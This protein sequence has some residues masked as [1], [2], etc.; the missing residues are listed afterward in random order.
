MP[1]IDIVLVEPLYEGNI[2][3]CARVMK[4]FGFT[5]LVLVNPPEIGGEAVARASHARDVL[6]GAERLTFDEV[7]GRSS[8]LVATTGEV[9]S[10]ICTSIR[11]P[12]FS[13]AELREMLADVDGRIAILFGREN[14]GLSNSPASPPGRTG[15]RAAWSS[16]PSS[17]TSTGS[18]TGSTT[19]HTNARIRS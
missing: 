1:A 9:G 4:N 3:F 5:N 8:L 14:W 15:S 7:V 10:S 19:R 11:M 6:E 18:S 17:I 13:P 2:G 16:T 12:F